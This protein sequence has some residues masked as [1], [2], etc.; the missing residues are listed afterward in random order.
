M[1]PPPNSVWRLPL[2]VSNAYLVADGDLTLIDAGTPWDA[3][4]I[5][6]LLARGGF[7]PGDVDRVLLTHFDVDHVGALADLGLDAPVYAAAPDAGY[8]DGTRRPP[9]TNRKGLLQRALDPLL[10]R[11][12]GPIRRVEDGDRIG[13]FAV[14]RT[15][16]HTPGHVAYVHGEYG[17]AFVGDL[18]FGDGDRLSEP[19]AALAFDADANAASARALAARLADAGVDVDV[20]AM[21]HGEPIRENGG[22]ALRRFAAE[23]RA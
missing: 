20:V 5:R 2:R 12:D 9:P 3:P 11:P 23:S 21:G 10:T 22:R 8:L 15:P 7:A 14:H 6:S 1:S 4:R 16:G 18:A 13:G 19:P 17:V